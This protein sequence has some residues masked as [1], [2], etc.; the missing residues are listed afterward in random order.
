MLFK[1]VQY[2]VSLSL[3]GPYLYSVVFHGTTPYFMQNISVL[4]DMKKN[5]FKSYIVIRCGKGTGHRGWLRGCS[6][7]N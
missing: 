6:F 3:F 1:Y 2:I 5:L 4:A 7:R